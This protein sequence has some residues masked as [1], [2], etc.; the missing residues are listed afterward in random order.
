MNQTLFNLNTIPPLTVSDEAALH[1]E[2][3]AFAEFGEETVID[4]WHGEDLE[5]PVYINEF[6]TA[7]QRQANPLHEISYR[8]CFKPQLPRFFIDR[9]SAPGD[10][11]LDPFM[12][13]GTTPIEAALAQRIPWGG[14]VSPLAKRLVEPRLTPPSN[15]EV[16]TR[17]KEIKKLCAAK[18]VLDAADPDLLVFYNANTLRDLVVLREYLIQR[19]SDGQLDSIDAWIRL[20]ATNRLTGHST[21]FFSVYTLP[22]NQAVTA[23][24]QRKINAKREQTPPFRDV[25]GIIEKKSKQLM[26]GLRDEDFSALERAR[27]EAQFHT[28]SADQAAAHFA[29]ESV[30]LVVT[31]PPFLDVVQYA[32]DNWLRCWFNGIDASA[33]PMWNCRRVEDWTASMTAVMEQLKQL[34]KPNGWV[35]FE[36]G[37][38]RNGRI[39]L[40]NHVVRAGVEAGL[41]P[42]LILINQQ[43]FTKTA[44]CWG[45]SNNTSGTNTNR[46]VLFRKCASNRQ[47]T[48]R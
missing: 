3:A 36:V 11:V 43:D 39:K 30:S 31:S 34:L 23:D 28:T 21:G 10:I 42:V 6:W 26:K 9:L 12:G 18:S 35:A 17:L 27:G 37:E 44:N 1:A 47:L 40:E 7:K 19:E 16:E 41:E 2:L 33:V 20:V 22:P 29:A 32:Q 14:D 15:D 8:A 45:V 5:L 25:F 48:E 46:I 38:V 13:R 24:R 4:A